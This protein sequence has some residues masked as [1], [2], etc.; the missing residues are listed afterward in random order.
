MVKGFGVQE[1]EVFRA[2]GIIERIQN[3]VSRKRG[4]ANSWGGRRR[5]RGN[6]NNRANL[7]NQVGGIMDTISDLV[8]SGDRVT[9]DMEEYMDKII[10]SKVLEETYFRIYTINKIPLSNESEVKAF[11]DILK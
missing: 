8:D 11:K 6:R 7:F 1:M 4:W 2:H 10:S 5:G 3:D 9:G